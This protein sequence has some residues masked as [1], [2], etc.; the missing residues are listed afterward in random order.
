MI[1]CTYHGLQAL[2]DLRLFA[3]GLFLFLVDRDVD[4]L[5]DLRGG[6][7]LLVLGDQ[8]VG[9]FVRYLDRLDLQ[10][11]REL[12]L[13]E[14]HNQNYSVATSKR[15]IKIYSWRPTRNKDQI[16]WRRIYTTTKLP[17]IRIQLFG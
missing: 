5:D 16:N 6:L 12:A 14:R 11:H 2:G 3:L 9:A 13:H 1:F 4:H 17:L 15:R 8:L 7:A 10:L